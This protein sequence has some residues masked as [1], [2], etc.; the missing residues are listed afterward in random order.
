MSFGGTGVERIQ[1]NV[2]SLW[3]GDDKDTGACQAFGDL[4]IELG[5]DGPT[6]YRRELE[7]SA[8]LGGRAEERTR[9]S[10]FGAAAGIAEMLLQSH[11]GEAQLLP[12]L[13][14]AWP[15]G[16]VRG[17]RARG[18]VEADIAWKDGRL[19]EAALRSTTGVPL[20]DRLGAQT[21]RITPDIRV[22]VRLG[23][24]LD[25]LK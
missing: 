1:F 9:R 2:N 14:S 20:T 16:H 4:V 7:G 8:G 17:L 25:P 22:P 19:T 13:P 15:E 21:V 5:H 10:D 11:L 12:A 3:E 23:P 6:G 24:A 18:G